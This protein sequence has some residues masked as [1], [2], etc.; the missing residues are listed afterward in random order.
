MYSDGASVVHLPTTRVMC[1]SA[2]Q[3]ITTTTTTAAAATTATTAAATTATSC[4]QYEGLFW[5]VSCGAAAQH[6][7]WPPHF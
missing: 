6:G 1:S 4:H 5:F 7:S 2:L 3:C